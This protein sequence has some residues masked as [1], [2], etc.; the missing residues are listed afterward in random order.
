METLRLTGPEPESPS[1][2]E[3]NVINPSRQ[4]ADLFGAAGELMYQMSAFYRQSKMEQ[5]L[6]WGSSSPDS[7]KELLIF[8]QQ[9]GNSSFPCSGCTWAAIPQEMG[10]KMALVYFIC[11]FLSQDQTVT[12]VGA[13][14]I[15]IRVLDAVTSIWKAP[16][17]GAAVRQRQTPGFP[18]L[19]IMVLMQHSLFFPLPFSVFDHS[20]MQL[21]KTRVPGS[22]Q[23]LCYF[24]PFC[25]FFNNI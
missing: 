1:E 4:C 10:K 3:T 5:R 2:K 17:L 23:Y 12:A 24:T 20:N 21:L 13:W 8:T 14:K 19:K 18:C 16:G 22:L 15:I 6:A 7:S 9:G 25:F 11:D